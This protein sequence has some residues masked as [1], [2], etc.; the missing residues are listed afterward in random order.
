MRTQSDESA[1]YQRLVDLHARHIGNAGGQV[2]TYIPELAKADP[3]WFGV[4]I[5]TVDGKVYEV[6]DSRQPFT[7]QS[8]SKPF[9]YG[10]ALADRGQEHVLNRVGVEPSGEAFNSIVFDER[11]NK[12][13]NPMV[14]AGAI[15]TTAMVDGDSHAHRLDRILDLF[16]AFAGERLTIDNDVYKSEKTTGHRNRAITYLELN[17]GMI[18]EP[19]DEHLDLYFRQCSILVDARQLAVM[20]ATLANNGINPITG[21]QA[22]APEH[23]R[24]LLSVMASCGMY[25]FSGE[26]IYRVGLPAKSGVA[27]GIIAVLPGQF[28]IGTFSPRLDSQGNSVR[29]IGVCEDVSK[30]FNL[31][32]FDKQIPASVTLRRSYRGDAVRSKRLRRPEHRQVLDGIGRAIQ[33]HE[34]QG[35]LFF[36]SM[37]RVARQVAKDLDGVRFMILDG[38]RVTGADFSARSLLADHR[39]ALEARGVRLM[40]AAFPPAL[41]DELRS[42]DASRWR[43]E[44]FRSSLDDALEWCEDQL[45]AAAVT[46]DDEVVAGAV[47]FGEMEIVEGLTRAELDLLAT[48]LRERTYVPGEPIVNEGHQATDLFMLAAGMATISVRLDDHRRKR[49]GAVGAGVTFGELALFEGGPRTADVIADTSCVCYVLNIPKLRAAADGCPSLYFKLLQNVGRTLAQR[50]RQAN[51]EIRSLE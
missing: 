44:D 39:A 2:A 12:P 7:I 28:G 5:A 38:R 26:W 24:A 15:A 49:L 11:G 45:I 25:D 36:A 4:S 31:H 1:I 18:E 41:R 47:P 19:V 30:H 14:N 34:L 48:I 27:G 20:A 8:I 51:A 29:G 16:E 9:V 35:G 23:V 10:L 33:V 46:V 21:R 42:G 6:G 32:L 13:F 43:E 40:L 22:L 3:D 50:L 37:E 17:S